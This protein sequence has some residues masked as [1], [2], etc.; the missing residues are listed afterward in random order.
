MTLS[1]ISPGQGVH[2]RPATRLCY[3]AGQ[4]G[5]HARN[6]PKTAYA[7]LQIIWSGRPQDPVST[8]T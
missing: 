3:A 2:G 6:M 8:A 7:V 1:W 5:M 4:A